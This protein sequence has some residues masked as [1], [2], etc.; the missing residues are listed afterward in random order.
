VF[1]VGDKHSSNSNR[2]VDVVANQAG[3]PVHLIDNVQD[4]RPEMLVGAR[5]VAVTAGSSTPSD[6]T[7][8]VIRFLQAY[9]PQPVPGA[10]G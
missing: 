3:R 1:V 5:T 10:V 6:I 4:I 8:E 2:L 7:R 9:E